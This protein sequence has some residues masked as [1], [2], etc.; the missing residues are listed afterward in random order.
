MY[1]AGTLVGFLQIGVG[2]CLRGHSSQAA[3][4]GGLHKILS[5]GA[6]VF[7]KEFAANIFVHP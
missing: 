5:Q 1:Y 6:Q 4:F 2:R 3:A 7:V